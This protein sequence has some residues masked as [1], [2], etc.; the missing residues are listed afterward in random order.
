MNLNMTG[1]QGVATRQVRFEDPTVG[2]LAVAPL[3]RHTIKSFIGAF[4]ADE[5]LDESELGTKLIPTIK[6]IALSAR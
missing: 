5:L 4:G 3:G 2:V 6:L 1:N